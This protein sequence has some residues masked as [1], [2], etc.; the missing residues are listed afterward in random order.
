MKKPVQIIIIIVALAAAAYLV[1][2]TLGKSGGPANEGRQESYFLCSNK[3][4]GKEIVLSPQEVESSIAARR[5]G[6]YACP[7]CG[8][9]DTTTEARKCESCGKLSAS[10][11]HGIA[12]KTCPHC[13]AAM[14]QIGE[15]TRED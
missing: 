10:L 6:T 5:E 14:A 7:H 8:K 13:G 12:Q 11:G 2:S 9:T 15:K 1:I 4:C 3:E